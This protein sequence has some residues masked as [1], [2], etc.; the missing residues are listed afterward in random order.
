MYAYVYVCVWW[1]IHICLYTDIYISIFMFKYISVFTYIHA[2]ITHLFKCIDWCCFYWK[3]V[4]VRNS[5]VILLKAPLVRITK[6][7][8][9]P[10]HRSR[11]GVYKSEWVHV[12]VVCVY[13][14]AYVYVCMYTSSQDLN[15]NGATKDSLQ[16]PAL[17]FLVA[18]RRRW[19]LCAPA[20][21]VA[22]WVGFKAVVIMME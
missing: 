4:F 6:N 16:V 1:Y 11:L 7:N 20:M 12:F 17:P 19:V 5:R 22:C 2:F 18:Q 3:I 8:T 14:C 9:N 21:V 10:S 13:M 15:N